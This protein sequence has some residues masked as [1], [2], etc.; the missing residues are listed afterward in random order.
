MADEVLIGDGDEGVIT[1]PFGS[2]PEEFRIKL[3]CDFFAFDC[4]FPKNAS[5]DVAEI[6]LLGP[7][8]MVEGDPGAPRVLPSRF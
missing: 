8:S 2:F 3:I 6:G 5:E 7:P 4:A 1:T